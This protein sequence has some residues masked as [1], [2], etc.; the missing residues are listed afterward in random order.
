MYPIVAHENSLSPVQSVPPASSGSPCMLA[1]HLT[2]GLRVTHVPSLDLPRPC[3]H[4]TTPSFAQSCAS[5]SNNSRGFP[6]AGGT[7][8]RRCGSRQRQLRCHAV[9][10]PPS[11]Y[12]P[13]EV[14]KAL[15][16]DAPTD[17]EYDAV[18]IGSGMGG[19]A[20]AGQ[21]AANGARVVVLEK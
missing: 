8:V 20:T 17:V 5:S 12:P 4:P 21:L 18:I 2:Q 9:A 19:L 10:A 15:P 14:V 1:L 11:P 6:G 16:T 13:A 3:P 7:S